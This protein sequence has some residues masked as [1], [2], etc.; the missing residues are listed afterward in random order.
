MRTRERCGRGRRLGG[1]G[2]RRRRAGA[3]ALVAAAAVAS[4]RR[5]LPKALLHPCPAPPR[6]QDFLTH[7]YTSNSASVKAASDALRNE[8][9][10]FFGASPDEYLV[11]PWGRWGE[12]AW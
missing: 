6:P 7:D 5:A 3:G 8:T 10:A 1:Q 2:G 4:C 12:A 11:S 9:L